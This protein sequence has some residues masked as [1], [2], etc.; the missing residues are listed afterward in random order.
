M[1]NKLGKIIIVF[2]LLVLSLL[3]L[4]NDVKASFKINGKTYYG[5]NEIFWG[6]YGTYMGVYDGSLWLGGKE[7]YCINHTLSS[8]GKG[9]VKPGDYKDDDWRSTYDLNYV[10]S[11]EVF[12]EIKHTIEANDWEYGSST[13]GGNRWGT[14]SSRPKKALSLD[15][16]DIKY[17]DNNVDAA[18]HAFAVEFYDGTNPNPFVQ[19]ALWGILQDHAELQLP[20]YW[21]GYGYTMTS[22]KLAAE[23]YDKWINEG[24][25]NLQSDSTRAKSRVR[26][27][28][29]IVG[30]F[31]I[32]YNEATFDRVV[33][34]RLD[35]YSITDQ[36]GNVIS[37]AQVTNS[38][39]IPLGTIPNH[40]DFYIKFPYDEDMDKV[41]I[42]VNVEQIDNVHATYQDV[43]VKVQNIVLTWDYDIQ[44]RGAIWVHRNCN[45]G[46]ADYEESFDDYCTCSG[47][48]EENCFD[49]S[50]EYDLE[51][52]GGENW[53][54]Y[55]NARRI[56]DGRIDYKKVST[57][58]EAPLDPPD[59]VDKREMDI[60]GYVWEDGEQ[61]K[62]QVINGSLD[63]NETRLGG[64]EVR[65]YR[66]DTGE[67]AEVH[68]GTNPT[69]TDRNGYYEF[70]GLNPTHKYFVVFTY[71]GML[72]TNTYGAGIPEYNTQ[73]WNVSSKGSELV[74]ERDNLNRRFVTISSTPSMYRTSAIFGNGYLSNG[75]NKIFATDDSVLNHYKNL[76]EN[77]LRYYLS[78][79][80]ARL[81]DGDANYINNI[82]WPIINSSGN[83]TEAKQ[84]LQYIWD[85][86][87]NAY[88]G[89]ESERDGKTS[90]AGGKYY[91]V[92]DNFALIDYWGNRITSNNSTDTWQGYRIIY[93]GQ[94]HINLGLVRR[95]KTDL[96]LDEDLYRTVVSIN[97]QDETY[98]YGIFDKRG[99]KVNTADAMVTQKIATS[100]Y[101][102]KVNTTELSSNLTETAEYP[103]KYA[104]IEIYIT[105]RMIIRNNSN[106]P[107]GVN[108][109]VA[110]I[111]SNY[112]SYSDSYTTTG[113]MT[114]KGI[115]GAFMY[116]NSDTT[117]GETN[118]T[119][120]DSGAFGLTVNPNSKYGT[121][122]ETGKNLSMKGETVGTDL[123]ISFDRN[124]I[125]EQ[126][127]V[128]ALDI[129]Y[130]L[131][132]NST[133]NS[134]FNCTYRSTQAGGDNHAYAILQDLF[135][136]T[137]NKK[138]TVYTGAEINAYST[139]FKKDF[140]VRETQN[141]YGPYYSYTTALSPGSTYRAA[142]VF[143]ADSTPGNLNQNEINIYDS[144]KSKTENDWDRASGFVLMDG[145]I[146]KITGNVWETVGKP[147]NYWANTGD[148]PTFD[149]SHGAEGITVEL[150][151]IKGGTEYI[152]ATTQTNSDGSYTFENYIPGLYTI[153]FI[154]GDNAEYDTKQHSKYT[155]FTL[156]GESY[157][158]AYN[159]QFYQS[160][161][162]NPKTN[163][164]QYWY[165]QETD[166]R[167]SDASDEVARRMEVNKV[168]QTYK[169]SDT[170][171]A[172]K[173]PT[174]YMAYAYTSLLDVEV[175][176]A[177]TETS[178][179]NPS[180]TI[181][182]VDFAL[183]PRTESRLKIN[184]E[185][186]RLRLILQ[187]GAVQFDA[188]TK[189]IREQGVPAVV[190]AMQ[191]NDITISMSSELVNGATL[192][193]TYTMTVTNIGPK[194]TITYYKDS[195]GNIIA[196]GF[197]N[198]NP[199]NI[200]YY[201]EGL[202]R[203]YNN[204]GT[205]QRNSD[206]W[207]SKTTAGTTAMRNLDAYRTET[208][209]TTTRADLVADF[210]SNNLNFAKVDYTGATIN[211][212][213]DL[214]TGAKADFET[215]YY[216]QKQDAG[217]QA[218]RPKIAKDM[219]DKAQDVYDSN[220]I[221][222]S[223]KNNAL[224]TTN[225]KSG[226]SVSENIVLSKVIS[227]NDDSTDTKS[228]TNKA[229]IVRINNTVS[230]IQDMAENDLVHKSEH[231]IVSDP[232]GI[233]NMYLGILL[234][235]VVAIIIGGGIVLIRKFV[236]NNK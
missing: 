42:D 218:L 177:V 154:Y 37:G 94:L 211:N 151:E 225:L 29:Y 131:G 233:G 192:E 103:V 102:Y 156:N 164:N 163:D 130:R 88:A 93:N 9:L 2:I 140:D 52:V 1:K 176:Y 41:N 122:S 90:L 214:Y 50:I 165:A 77:Q 182:H 31:T 147:A 49:V 129:T 200:V 116:P 40:Q 113:G 13:G 91:P 222:V 115:E 166:V 190:Q 114:I 158:C 107:T 179:Q 208:I 123:Y 227:V 188:D 21:Y 137:D 224:V 101:N 118:L 121:E 228:Y 161:K 109:V 172:L 44:D 221:V 152:R 71:D 100:D 34:S 234:T 69:L 197:Y 63:N 106:I 203:T 181:Q 173:H 235:L 84:V 206:I 212:G 70:I 170:T 76:V 30:P 80:N 67:L 169:Y 141:K 210:V 144:T 159:G 28:D 202:I 209:E 112:Y 18:L 16:Q 59:V 132:E 83:P 119:A 81:E 226:E 92:Y 185:V 183:T 223:N 38:E 213:W 148:Y 128:L 153:R 99:V 174:D 32:T 75:Y 35:S 73:A 12:Y 24:K 178:T 36:D 46:Y 26:G 127:D 168:L 51:T 53:G 68:K 229:R 175:E 95:P 19:H 138:M 231:V 120:Y 204:S 55:Q 39:G 78:E 8:Q 58:L 89:Y 157:K 124:V 160:A 186:T 125:L 33:Y 196:L 207:V 198:E 60:A 61:G 97:G 155:E 74:N 150:I 64:I 110:Y 194:D 105:Y 45:E 85:C 48:K 171:S 134:K 56:I 215:E 54:E 72:Y 27:T 180:Y 98:T 199:E 111:D 193:I 14:G 184:K 149:S 25:A 79:V 108:E 87:I 7:W 189:T 10:E 11:N 142:G 96:Q 133:T 4:E 136:N 6:N 219:E 146:R 43:Y 135:R 104:P 5:Y 201:E 47:W 117:Y 187:N 65:L 139:F 216:K 232:T 126:N 82:Y 57:H 17:V 23:H 220:A 167:Y 15:Y 195:G 20:G 3:F 230:R 145:G 236:I 143:D 205:F 66:A 62:D 191:G 217:E 22:L 162:A 86:R